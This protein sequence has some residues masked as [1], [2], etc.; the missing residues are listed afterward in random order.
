MNVFL[1]DRRSGS[2][3]CVGD[4]MA[5]MMKATQPKEKLAPKLPWV[6]DY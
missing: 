3:R 1:W 2:G 4:A 6:E 5:G